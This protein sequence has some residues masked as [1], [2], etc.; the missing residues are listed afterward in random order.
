MHPAGNDADYEVR[1]PLA[2]VA[3]PVAPELTRTTSEATPGL[4]AGTRDEASA[5][6][7]PVRASPSAEQSQAAGS[8][9]ANRAGK[10]PRAS[11]A[12]PSP[13]PARGATGAKPPGVW[14]NLDF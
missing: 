1:M 5:H 9:P 4:T 13:T 2:E 3:Q 6:A 14:R 11:G 10:K 12:A 8:A 7:A